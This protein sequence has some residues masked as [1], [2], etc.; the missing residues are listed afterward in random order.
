MQC[1]VSP[2]ERPP[3]IFLCIIIKESNLQGFPSVLPVCAY[4][5]LVY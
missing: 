2:S 5:Q 3:Y 1:E 4:L